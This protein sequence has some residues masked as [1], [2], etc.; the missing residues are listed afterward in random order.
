M[1]TFLVAWPGQNV[2]H[3]QTPFADSLRRAIHIA[4]DSEKKLEAILQ[5]CDQFQS[6][7]RDTVYNYALL[8]VR[9]ANETG[10]ELKIARAKLAFAN[11]YFVWGWTDSSMAVIEEALPLV[12]AQEAAARSTYFKLLRQKAMCYGGTS[13][14]AEGLDILYGLLDLA[15]K[16][17]DT[18]TIATTCNTIGSFQIAT[19]DAVKA[20]A[21]IKTAESF[22]S[23]VV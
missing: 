5:Y 6:L 14:F 11:S 13:R 22:L 10:D 20:I 1:L 21:M 15:K 2:S 19:G 16:Y 17:K 3:A 12:N 7:N 23:G 9:M 8:A 18:L 4:A